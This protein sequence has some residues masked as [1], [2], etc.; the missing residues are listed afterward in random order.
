MSEKP[1]QSN[2]VELPMT[3]G[4]RERLTRAVQ[5]IIDAIPEGLDSADMAHAC[6]FAAAALAAT[7]EAERD[8][9]VRAAEKAWEEWPEVVDVVEVD[10][11]P[12]VG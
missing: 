5:S 8:S 9:F 12:L 3:K 6:L 2:V 4:R 7:S 10:P 11:G 1:E